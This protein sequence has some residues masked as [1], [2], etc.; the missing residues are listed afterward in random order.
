MN[1]IEAI[2]F[3]MDGTLVNSEPIYRKTDKLFAESHNI[4]LE[5]H[6]LPDFTGFSHS[7]YM[8]FFKQKFHLSEKKEVL[9]EQYQEIFISLIPEIRAFEQTVDLLKEA[10][11][12]NIPCGLASG[13]ARNII[14]KVLKATHLNLYFSSIYSSDE[15]ENGK[16]HP[17][18]FFFVA[19]KLNKQP[20]KCLVIEDSIPGIQA[21]KKA[22]MKVVAVRTD[23]HP[24]YNETEYQKAD[25]F[26]KDIRDFNPL[27]IIHQFF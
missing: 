8:D 1:N 2:I 6:P 7:Y 5:E 16:P 4:S 24:H 21:G 19:E 26:Y 13:S 12:R 14:N 27:E 23:K 3:D 25:I 11:L 22:G 18:I 9:A 20:F 15:V 10:H 17:D